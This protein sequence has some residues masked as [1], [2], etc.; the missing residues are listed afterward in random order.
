[1]ASDVLL[2]GGTEVAGEDPRG[3]RVL[4]ALALPAAQE[5]AAALASL[6]IRF[7]ATDD[8]VRLGEEENDLLRPD[9]PGD[10]VVSSG[11]LRVV[12]LARPTLSSTP[13]AT[14][15]ALGAAWTVWLG[16]PLGALLLTL[17]RHHRARG[18]TGG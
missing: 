2:V 13:V 4:D 16:W 17:R 5:R 1:M 15:V 8:S 9:V 18:G 6:G 12:E 11:E 10:P 3:P 7:V 14:A